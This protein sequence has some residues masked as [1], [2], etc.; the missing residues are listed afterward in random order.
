MASLADQLDIA[1]HGV[2][3]G[4]MEL[5]NRVLQ[6]PD[7]ISPVENQTAAER[8]GVKGGFLSAITN[9]AVD[10]TVWVATLLSRKFPTKH[11]LTGAIPQRFI[12]AHNEFSGLSTVARTSEGFFRGTHVPNLISLKMRREAEALKI[13]NRIFDRISHRRNWEQ[14]MPIVSM[15]LEGQNPAGASPD[16]RDLAAGIRGDMN[17]LWQLLGKTHKVSGGFD[18]NG[19]ARGTSRPFAPGEAPKFLRDYL[20]HIPLLG[21]EST[22]TLGGKE[23][24]DKFGKSK[25]A[26]AIG[27]GKVN[28]ADVWKLNRDNTVTSD[29]SAYQNFMDK[30]GAQVYSPRIFKRQRHGIKLQS[31]EG[32]GLFVTDLNVILQK[33]IHSVARTYSLNAPLSSQERALASILKPDGTRSMPTSEPVL[34][35]VLNQGLD[36]TG[37]TFARQQVA[38]TNNFEQRLQPHTVNAPTLGALKS[39]VRNLKGSQAEDEI[40]FG[41]MFNSIR[42]KV[43]NTV[44]RVMKRDKMAQVEGAISSLEAQQKDRRLSNR[45]VSFF[46]STTLG[47]NPLSSIKNLFQPLLTTAPAIGVGPTLAGYKVLRERLPA[48]AQNFR[49]QHRMMK[50]NP[51]IGAASRINLALEKAHAETFPELAKTGIRFD[52]RAFEVDETALITD[53]FGNKRFRNYDDYMKLLLQTFTQTEGANQVVSFYGARDALYKAGRQGLMDFP[54]GVPVDDFISFQAADTVRATQFVPGP[55]S[56]TVLQSMVPAP[57]RMFT[58]F[59]IRLGNFFAESTVRGALADKQL[60]D[61]GFLQR[62]VGGRNMGTV[63]R[64]YLLGRGVTEGLRETIGVDMADAVG[65]TGPYSNIVPSGQMIPVLPM[66]PVPSLLFGAASYATTRDIKDLQPVELPIFGEIHWPKTLLPGGIAVTRASRALRR[67]R[68]DLGGFTDDDERLMFRGDTTDLALSML[69][70]PLEKERRMRLDIERLNA[71]RLQ[72]RDFRRKYSVA[73]RNYDT[74]GMGQLEQQ[75]AEAFPDFGQLGL[76]RHDKRRYDQQQRITA[77]QRMIRTLGKDAAFMENRL[78]ETDPDLIMPEGMSPLGGL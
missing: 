38:G 74:E 12:G 6:Y 48:Y 51:S 33:Y 64:T 45:I 53:P 29:F 46:Y 9:L 15:L 58:S 16:L 14:E 23:A 21:P 22:F 26:Q 65:L 75:W 54:D 52:P 1:M 10:P 76:S 20:P 36:A 32:A 27:L 55:G 78:Y 42:N 62:L 61:A 77:V 43:S 25:R 31:S 24:L 60:Q 4:D 41:N 34:V 28:P 30:V 3:F 69:G 47:L 37:G 19:V 71:N 63:A 72:I 39:L 59:P 56:K 5:M 13:G 35:Q 40:L 8:L 7:T 70:I 57:L 17:D 50:N 73:V 66:S 11:F 67:Y 18:Q 44:G 49:H 68:P 2:T